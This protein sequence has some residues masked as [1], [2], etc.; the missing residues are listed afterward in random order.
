[1][2]KVF[3]TLMPL[4]SLSIFIV[5]GCRKQDQTIPSP[6]AT[7]SPS[8]A[9]AQNGANRFNSYIAQSWYNLMMKLI[10]ETPGHTPP[11]AARSFG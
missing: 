5:I 11:I 7:A 3:K 1:M 10:A 8:D 4:I 9:N 6:N 2:K